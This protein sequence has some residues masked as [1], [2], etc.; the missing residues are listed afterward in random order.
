MTAYILGAA[1]LILLILIICRR[2]SAEFRRR[3]EQPK[4]QFL[5]N[6]GIGS[7]NPSDSEQTDEGSQ[8]IQ[9]KEANGKH[10]P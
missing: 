5:A 3:S 8:F 1:T 2:Y 4:F 6:L 7:R 9:Q 10:E